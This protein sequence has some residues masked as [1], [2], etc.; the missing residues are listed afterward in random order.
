MDHHEQYETSN[1]SLV[2]KFESERYVGPI[3]MEGLNVEQQ[4]EKHPHDTKEASSS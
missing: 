1:E 3:P 4:E 2:Y